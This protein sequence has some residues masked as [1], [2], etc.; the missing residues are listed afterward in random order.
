MDAS[1]R[2]RFIARLQRERAALLR[3][4]AA[5]TSVNGSLATWRELGTPQAPCDRSRSTPTDGRTR[6]ALEEI[7]AG[8]ARLATDSYGICTTC[9]REI[10]L[11]RLELVPATPYCLRCARRR[12]RAPQG[13]TRF[14]A[15]LGKLF[16]C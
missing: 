15:A 5:V 13:A 4:L 2:E 16:R 9:G 3:Q 8:L 6:Q 7:D 1:R 12:P 14:A 11:E 10:A